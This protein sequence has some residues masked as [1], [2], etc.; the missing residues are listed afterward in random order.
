MWFTRKR[1]ENIVTKENFIL[2][3]TCNKFLNVFKEN[4]QIYPGPAS[5][6]IFIVLKVMKTTHDTSRTN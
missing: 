1:V 3:L 5:K 6:R 2:F 4:T